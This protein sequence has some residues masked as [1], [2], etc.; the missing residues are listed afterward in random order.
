MEPSDNRDFYYGNQE[1][2]SWPGLLAKLFIDLTKVVEAEARL[3]GASIGPTLT[4]VLDRF[5]LQIIAATIALTGCLLLLIAAVLL[6]HHWLPLWAACGVVG[7]VT[8][9]VAVPCG[10]V[11]RGWVRE[12]NAEA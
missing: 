2:Q 1:P 10:L 8:L 4:A 5:L 7:A 9:A 11:N 6:I 12:N 3:A